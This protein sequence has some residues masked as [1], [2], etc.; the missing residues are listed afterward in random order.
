[1]LIIFVIRTQIINDIRYT[2]IDTIKMCFQPKYN[3][4]NNN[5]CIL[6]LFVMYTQIKNYIR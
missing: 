1:M 2:H 3:Y 5:I 6:R 4:D